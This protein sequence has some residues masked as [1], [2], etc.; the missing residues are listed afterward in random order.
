[1][2]ARRINMPDTS[3]FRTPASIL[4]AALDKEQQAHDFYER[5]AAH[6]DVDFVKELLEKLQN[7]ESKHI[8]LIRQMKGR[9]EA[10]KSLL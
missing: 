7:E 10:G 2:T 1:M 5:L 6:C 3:D 8:H 4:D 9:L